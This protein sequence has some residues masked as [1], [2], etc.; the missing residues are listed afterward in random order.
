M[1]STTAY[2]Y[3]QKQQVLMI[4]TSG[5]YF[6]RRWEPMYVKNLKV[7][8]GVDNVLLFEFVNQDQKPVNISG[9]TIT[10]RLISQ[11]GDVLL[12]SKDLVVLNATYGRAK[13]TLTTT[14]LNNI[15][16]QPASWSLERASGD[17]YEPVFTDAYSGARGTIDVMDAVYPDFIPSQEMI[18]PSYVQPHPDD[19]SRVHTSEVYVQG[20]PQTTFQL[21]FDNFTGN[22]K[23]QG[24]ETLLGPWYDIGEQHAYYNQFNRDHFTVL[25]QHNYLRFEINQYGQ[26]AN[27]GNAVVSG[28]VVTTLNLIDGGEG[29]ET[30]PT[31]KIDNGVIKAGSRNRELSLEKDN[32]E[33]QID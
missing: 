25:G 15:D 4:N 11:N 22:L 24:S 16:A 31:V 20:R 26:G 33:K 32:A 3:Q 5:A 9:S 21:D 7:S 6:D 2:L 17:L 18:V 19:K 12:L 23:A 13:V 30:A 14:D 27:V 1:Y 8:K 29:Y 28:G 10:F